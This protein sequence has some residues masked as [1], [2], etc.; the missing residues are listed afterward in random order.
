VQIIKVLEV[1]SMSDGFNLF[2]FKL[3]RPDYICQS[4]FRAIRAREGLEVFLQWNG[5]E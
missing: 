4:S 3:S 2:I 1:Y 5:L